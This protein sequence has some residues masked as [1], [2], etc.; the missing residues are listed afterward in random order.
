MVSDVYADDGRA[1]ANAS[2]H[3]VL[4]VI[5][6]DA[7]P[8][9]LLRVAAQLQL[10][11]VPPSSGALTRRPDGRLVMSFEIEGL[12]DFTVDSIRR[13]LL[14]ITAVHSAD[15]CR[16]ERHAGAARPSA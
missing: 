7:E 5:L 15:V 14:Q 13:K 11:N 9:S 12:A 3:G 10:G 16:V 6:I 4:F 1:A 8:D 2:K